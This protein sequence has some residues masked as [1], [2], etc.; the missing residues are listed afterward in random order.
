[1]DKF[2]ANYCY[3][4]SNFII[5]NLPNNQKLSPYTNMIR[6]VQ[7]IIM[8]GSPTIASNFL[9]KELNLE[10][11]YLEDLMEVKF[12]SNENL[13][14]TRTIKGDVTRNDY[15][16]NQFYDDLEQIFD[17][18][19]FLRNLTLA[20]CPISQILPDVTLAFNKQI[21]DFYI[22]FL[23][24]V[25]EVDGEGHKRQ[26]VLDKQRDKAFERN[27]INVVRINTKDIRV[28]NYENFKKEFIAIYRPNKEKVEQYRDYLHIN[29]KD[30]EVQIKLTLIIRLQV[31]LL[32]LLD[33]GVLTFD[34]THWN[35]NVTGIENKNALK[36]AISDLELWLG[37]IGALFNIN[38]SMPHIKITVYENE[39]QYP[40]GNNQINIMIN[41][42]KR[43]DDT[44]LNTNGYHIRTDFDDDAN[45]FSVKINEPVV[46]S[47]THKLHQQNLQFLLE[48]LFGFKQFNEGQL[49]IIMNCLNGENTVGLLPT[50]GGK[51]LTYQFCVLLQPAISFVVVPI[52]SLMMDQINNINKK[53]YISHAS[54]INSDLSAEESSCRLKDFAAGKYFFLIISPERFQSKGFREELTLVNETKAL[55]IAVIDEVHCLSEWGHDF[56]TSYLALAKSIRKFAPS[57]RFM[58]LTA[59][60]SSKVL[61]DIMTELE[62]NSSNVITISNF[63]RDELE[64]NI[65]KM[66]RNSKQE[67]LM[68]YLRGRFEKDKDPTL[69]FTQTVNGDTGC[70]KL[71]HAIQSRTGLQTGFYSGSA[72]RGVDS[73][74]FAKYKDEIQTSFMDDEIDVLVATKAFGMGID[75][76]NIRQTIHYGIPSSL[77][78]FYQEA[79]RAGRDKKSSSCIILYSP[80][81]LNEKQLQAI[82]GLNT[83]V[84]LLEQEK[85]RLTGDLNTLLFFLSTNLTD[86][87]QEVE[88]IYA[89]HQEYFTS[90]SEVVLVDFHNDRERERKEKSIYRL[91]LLGI[92]GDWTINWKFRQ[93][94]VE[95]ADWDENKV[96]NHLTNHIKKYDFMFTLNPYEKQSEQYKDIIHHFQNSNEPFLKRI[97]LVLLKWYND[98]VIYSRK[99]SMLLMK[100]YADQFTDSRS[101]QEKIETYFKRNDDVYLLEKN[102]AQK[103][104]LKD[105]Y[106]IFYVQEEGKDDQL[107]PLSTFKSLKI[108][109]SRFLESYNN[110]ISLNLING[111]ICLAEGEFDSIDGRDRMA[112]AIREIA[113]LDYYLREEMLTSILATADDFLTNEQKIQL[114]EVLI[115]NG[116]DII[117]DLKE[118]HTRLEDQY[119]YGSMIKTLHSSI[120]EL[121][122]GGYPWEM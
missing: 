98:N 58:A 65:V 81:Q 44:V 13:N 91:A 8:R 63:T 104:R 121:S 27:G 30:Y 110:D 42:F 53:H 115:S 82:F 18:L 66:N 67:Y 51:S 100:Q 74:W 2:T 26:E 122:Y 72:P 59:T 70:Y 7:N 105:W 35:F 60:A 39:S 119:S 19:K 92:V 96:I 23:K 40:H 90:G 61:K 49:E 45:Y 6:V 28:K 57:A 95:L 16:A 5:T 31:L 56:R 107:R 11:D 48:N 103:D 54:F 36:L 116:F 33:R 114:S 41:I 3:S 78:S 118:I 69:V 94:E 83:N 52:K 62:I 64:F 117:E 87:Q 113:R 1:M 17:R 4:N 10:R 76:G 15:P 109:V 86:I 99:R 37:H 101:L 12:I 24:T 20:E 75:K 50:G 14:W 34:S 68:Q 25:I 55:S 22:P 47:L 93:M 32:E 77:E 97:L 21:V 71:S 106:K 85:R 108:T 84:S 79:G 112:V 89:F 88:E 29:Q 73:N 38:I 43:W 46:Y 9:R 120:R 102:V 111:L 80:D